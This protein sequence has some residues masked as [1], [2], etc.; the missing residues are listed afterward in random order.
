MRIFRELR[1]LSDAP[2]GA[3]LVL[4][5]FDGVHRGHAALI[6]AARARQNPVG[7]VTFAPHPRLLTQ[8]QQAPFLL[9]LAEQKYSALRALGADFCVELPFTREFASISA[10][11]FVSAILL[12]R[13]RAEHVVCGYN[14]RFGAA[15]KGDVALLEHLGAQLGFSV[16][17]VGPVLGDDGEA[18][19]STRIRNCLRSGD[20]AGATAVLGRPWTIEVRF[21]R[22][23]DAR[24]TRG[25]FKFGEYL[26]PLPARYNARV[27]SENDILVDA[28]LIVSQQNHV[29]WLELPIHSSRQ[30]EGNIELDLIELI[31]PIGV[32][33][34]RSETDVERTC[35]I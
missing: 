15:R 35:Y 26:K 7:V 25:Y 2:R 6:A 28:R 19:S 21:Q 8:P 30:R 12:G 22:E 5:S 4:G 34:W 27:R 1:D 9:T 23:P 11:D 32:R 33:D 13:L 31:R 24:D 17:S 3:S 16:E 29:G 14:F 20:I 10:E 18:Y